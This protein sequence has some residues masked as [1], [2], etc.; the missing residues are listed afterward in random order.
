MKRKKSKKFLFF[1]CVIMFIAPCLHAAQAG[2]HNKNAKRDEDVK[3]AVK[4]IGE[5]MVFV[6]GGCF[7]MGDTFGDGNLNE[8]PVHK[9]CLDDFYIGKYDVT[10]GQWRAVMGE[11][12]SYS[13]HFEDDYPVQRASWN[14]VQE[15]IRKLNE[16]SGQKYRLPTEAEWEYAARSGGKQEEWPGTNN[17][18]KLG[19]YAWYKAN[20]GYHMHPVGRKKPN[21]L[22]LYD[23]A[24][25]VW[26]WV[27]DWYGK[28]Y[29]AKGAETKNPSGP[30]DGKYKVLRGG[31]WSNGARSLRASMRSKSEPSWK[32]FDS[33]GFRLALSAK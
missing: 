9:V 33:F 1:L 30:A 32:Y 10:Q 18:A 20:S 31:S 14:D 4:N 29:Y 25:N 19:D 11:N 24:G 15:F 17:R 12:A 6:R 27:Q 7:R 22:G 28:N 21:G 2:D 8:R 13:E 23:M 16:E 5:E 3:T 26:Q